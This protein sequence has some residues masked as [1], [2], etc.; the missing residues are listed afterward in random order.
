ME[1]VI[2]SNIFSIFAE[3]VDYKNL[4]FYDEKIQK[5]KNLFYWRLFNEVLLNEAETIIISGEFFFSN[6]FDK[7]YLPKNK[8][9]V[10]IFLEKN[11]IIDELFLKN[12]EFLFNKCP[13]EFQIWLSYDLNPYKQNIL[14][15]ICD[16]KTSSFKL[17]AVII[18]YNLEI[19]GLSFINFINY[20]LKNRIYDNILIFTENVDDLNS[21]KDKIKFNNSSKLIFDKINI[22]KIEKCMKKNVDIYLP[23]YSFNQIMEFDILLLDELKFIDK[24]NNIFNKKHLFFYLTDLKNI[25]F[26]NIDIYLEGKN[27]TPLKLL[28]GNF[29]Q[30]AIQK[31][32]LS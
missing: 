19:L 13:N 2:F 3:L 14:K 28:D 20:F 31:I 1:P 17:N 9:I 11:E 5:I 12:D 30:E 16:I 24:I 26:K 18:C 21:I 25:S 32:E 15:E 27:K 22:K 10:I 6:N 7:S 23:H 4:Y 29:I 8:N